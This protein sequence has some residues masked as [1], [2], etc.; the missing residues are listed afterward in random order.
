MYLDYIFFHI[1]FFLALTIRVVTIALG[2]IALVI[3]KLGVEGYLIGQVAAFLAVLPIG[4]WL[5]RRDIKFSK[6]IFFWFIKL[7]RFGY[8]FIFAG[9][10]YWLFSSIDRWMLASFSSIKEVGI[11]SVSSRFSSIV[12]FVSTAFGQ[13][14]SPLAMKIRSDYPNNYRFIYGQALLF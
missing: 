4:L 3:F 1:I 12:F 8:P 2:I 6:L 14:W 9:F 11:Y 10:G 5:I 7:V 13:A